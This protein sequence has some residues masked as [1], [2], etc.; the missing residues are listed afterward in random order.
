MQDFTILHLFFYH[1]A[2]GFMAYGLLMYV[3]PRK[4][5]EKK[6]RGL[7]VFDSF[8]RKSVSL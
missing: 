1:I 7:V 3:R 4:T 5:Y 6:L 8:Y 2:R